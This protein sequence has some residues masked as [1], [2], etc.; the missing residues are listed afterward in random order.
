MRKVIFCAKIFNTD[1]WVYGYYFAQPSLNC[2][3][4]ISGDIQ[5]NVDPNT[6]GEWTGA[7]DKNHERIFEGD[8]C[9]ITAG[10]T[11]LTG[12][13]QMRGGAF[14]LSAKRVIYTF[15]DIIAGHFDI[16]VIGDRIA[17]QAKVLFSTD[18]GRRLK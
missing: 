17:N 7:F 10:N 11:A 12:T 18:S 5:W 13:I 4:I 2:H 8:L 14:V 15:S 1:F 6:V 3:Y 16:E 9:R